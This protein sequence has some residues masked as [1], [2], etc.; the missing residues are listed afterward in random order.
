[1]KSF[2]RLVGSLIVALS[3]GVAGGAYANPNGVTDVLA[4]GT[5]NFLESSSGAGIWEQFAF[6]GAYSVLNSQTTTISAPGFYTGSLFSQVIQGDTH[7]PFGGLDFVYQLTVDLNSGVSDGIHRMTVNGFNSL[8]TNVGIIRTP[9]DPT[10]VGDRRPTSVDRDS[11]G[12]TIGWNFL[13]SPQCTPSGCFATPSV[14]AQGKT[15]ALLIVYTDATVYGHTSASVI[16]GSV[17]STDTFAP[18]PEPET[19]AM[20]LAGLGLMGFVARRRRGAKTAA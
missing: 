12:G 4:T 10:L 11:T 18:V 3:F 14:L 15:S 2:K 8:L 13:P 1:M 9:T 20:M 17:T 5:T 6:T 7:N 16:D 19:Y